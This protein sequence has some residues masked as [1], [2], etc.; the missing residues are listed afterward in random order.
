MA[1]FPVDAPKAKVIRTLEML[2]FRLLREGAHIS[3]VRQEPDDKRTPL[4]PPN[5][6]RIKGSTLR[7]ICTQASI[8]RDEFLKAYEDA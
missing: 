3:M 7:A 2:G 4:T 8:P 5:H 1:K 6:R